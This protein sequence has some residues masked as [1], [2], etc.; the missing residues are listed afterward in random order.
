MSLLGK[1]NMST[2]FS[3]PHPDSQQENGPNYQAPR[4]DRGVSSP[5]PGAKRSES[6]KEHLLESLDDKPSK[7]GDELVPF[8][9]EPNQVEHYFVDSLLFVD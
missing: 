1:I 6:R 7:S 8:R 3:A 2:P 5:T 9:G 4:T